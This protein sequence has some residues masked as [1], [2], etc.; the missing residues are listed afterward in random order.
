MET[1]VPHFNTRCRPNATVR[2]NPELIGQKTYYLFY[3]S[4]G[5]YFTV[6]TEKNKQMDI[7]KCV[8][9]Q[10]NYLILN[11]IQV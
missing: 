6:L 7:Q 9:L 10:L 4:F 11:G 2:V 3:L 1:V 8:H 5:H